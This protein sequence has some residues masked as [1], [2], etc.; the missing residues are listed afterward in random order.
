MPPGGLYAISAP[1]GAGKTTLARRLVTALPE[2]VVSI[3]HTTRPRRPGEVDGRDYYFV[4]HATFER[5]LADREFLEFAEVFGNWYGTSKTAIDQALAAGKIVI[6]DIDWQ[7]ARAVK[8]VFPQAQSIFILP[9][10]RAELERRLRDRGQDSEDVIAER[11]EVAAAEISHHD[12]YDHVVVNDDL[13]RALADLTAIMQ[14]QSQRARA[15]AVDL[16]ALLAE[17]S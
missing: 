2:V 16:Q 9:P 7:G 4:D 6:L 13:E 5:M 8:R 11:M 3:S 15:V 10:S 17:A 12:E 1:S 14:G